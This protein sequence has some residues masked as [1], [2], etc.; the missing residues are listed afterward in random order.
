MG[1]SK[2]RLMPTERCPVDAIDLSRPAPDFFAPCEI[3]GEDPRTRSTII[4]LGKCPQTCKWARRIQAR[5]DETGVS[6][7]VRNCLLGGRH[8]LEPEC[9]GLGAEPGFGAL[10]VL[11]FGFGQPGLVV[12][13]AGDEQVVDNPCELVR[14]GGDRLR[15][16]ELRPHAAEEVP[17]ARQM[18]STTVS[19]NAHGGIVAKYASSVRFRSGNFVSGNLGYGLDCVNNGSGPSFTGTRREERR[20]HQRRP[21]NWDAFRPSRSS[22]HWKRLDVSGS[23]AR[24]GLSPSGRARS[25]P[26]GSSRR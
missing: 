7:L 22:F 13:L 26:A 4:R 23:P 9:P 14:G 6:D 21:C 10:A 11:V 1:V 18:D 19:G 24:E 17:E 8:E 16:A 2:Y 25:P 12:G 20:S 3:C 5:L 15:G